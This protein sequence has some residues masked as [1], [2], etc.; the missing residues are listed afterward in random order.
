[1]ISIEGNKRNISM[2][3]VEE[4]CITLMAFESKFLYTSLGV[5]LYSESIGSLMTLSESMHHV[6]VYN[7]NKLLE[8]KSKAKL[9]DLKE[10][11]HDYKKSSGSMRNEIKFNYKK[12]NRYCLENGYT[13]QSIPLLFMVMLIRDL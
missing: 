13:Q 6:E 10:Y 2:E 12:V 5:A 4:V 9:Q 8:D 3:E 11:L 1:M 7:I